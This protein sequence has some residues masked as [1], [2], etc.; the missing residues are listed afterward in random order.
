M[1]DTFFLN[2]NS[3]KDDKEAIVHWKKLKAD[4]LRY[5]CEVADEESREEAV[6]VCHAQYFQAYEIEIPIALPLRMSLV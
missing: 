4:M 2:K 6:S 3:I 1:I 5:I